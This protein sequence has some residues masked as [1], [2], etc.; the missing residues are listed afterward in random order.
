[1]TIYRGPCGYVVSAHSR[2]GGWTRAS[3][4]SLNDRAQGGRTPKILLPYLPIGLLQ[5]TNQKSGSYEC[6]R[7]DWNSIVED[8]GRGKAELRLV[9]GWT[10]RATARVERASGRACVWGGEGGIFP[11]PHMPINW[12]TLIAEKDGRVSLH[13]L[14]KFSSIVAFWLGV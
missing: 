1:M 3:T 11:R 10:R 14:R 4:H 13:R 9:G 6:R 5:F 2:G 7:G 12:S 8:V